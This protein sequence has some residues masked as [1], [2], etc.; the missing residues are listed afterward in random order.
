MLKTSL[1][2]N[3]AD[4]IILGGGPAGASCALWLKQMGHEPF[5][6]ERRERLGGLQNDNPYL[7]N[8]IAGTIGMTGIEYARAI[9]RQIRDTAATVLCGADDV[10]IL[11]TAGGFGVRGTSDGDRFSVEAPYL[12][13]ATGV[14]AR[15]GGLQ[16]SRRII[17]GPGNAVEHAD[18][19][20]KRVA[21]LGGG[22]NAFENY[23]FVR[24]A[25]ASDIRV[26]ARTLVARRSFLDFVPASDLHVGS[27]RVDPQEMT[28]DGKEF[29]FFIVLYGWKPN[30]PSFGGID[31]VLRADGYI[32]TASDTCETNIPCVYAVG[33]VANRAH[34]CCV[35][36]MADGVVA[37]KAIQRD[38]ETA[39]EKN[40]TG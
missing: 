25:G 28:V 3:K 32:A 13:V 20:G 40:S 2:G 18:L 37:A 24:R 8:W 17:I 33:E 22:D 16:A 21:I 5:I 7:N 31:L 27:Y 23:T 4:A 39:L 11:R 35:T 10:E 34:P 29:D 12:V 6:V 14:S 30:M 15:T 19:Q 9:D 26:F 38:I 36:A 1:R